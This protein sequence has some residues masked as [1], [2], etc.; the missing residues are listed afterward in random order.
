MK[1]I[2]FCLVLNLIS[3]GY[4]LAGDAV[5]IEK[6]LNRGELRLPWSS[7]KGWLSFISALKVRYPELEVVALLSSNQV[8]ARASA[9]LLLV[10]LGVDDLMYLYTGAWED[11][12]RFLIDEFDGTAQLEELTLLVEGSVSYPGGKVLGSGIWH[13]TSKGHVFK[14]KRTSKLLISGFL[15][16]RNGRAVKIEG[17]RANGWEVSFTKPAP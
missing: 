14:L 2:L 12:P 16:G 6:A 10:D 9:W 1:T 7:E 17:S 8:D 11:A 3:A 4:A 13:Q 5:E 15:V